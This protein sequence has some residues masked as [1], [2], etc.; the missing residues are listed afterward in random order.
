MN[1]R[2]ADNLMEEPRYFIKGSQI[3]SL[4]K[5]LHIS[6]MQLEKKEFLE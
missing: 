4:R 6:R 3:A 2:D 5:L 1:L